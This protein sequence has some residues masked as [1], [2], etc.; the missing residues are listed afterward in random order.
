MKISGKEFS[1]VAGISENTFWIYC[2]MIKKANGMKLKG[3]LKIG[4]L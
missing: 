3:E 1:D 4:N 2:K